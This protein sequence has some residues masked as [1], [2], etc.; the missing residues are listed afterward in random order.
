MPDLVKIRINKQKNIEY[1]RYLKI[2]YKSPE[3]LGIVS[4]AIREQNKD[5]I[6]DFVKSNNLPIKYID[7]LTD[8][9]VKPNYYCPQIVQK[10]EREKQQ[11]LGLN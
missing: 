7:I 9:F 11:V 2:N 10:K 5:L 8:N 1:Q 3:P 6:I 4:S